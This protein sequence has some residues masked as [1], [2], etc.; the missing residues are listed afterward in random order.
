MKPVAPTSA[1]VNGRLVV[2]VAPNTY[3]EQG[4]SADPPSM[5][6]APASARL[7]FGDVEPPTIRRVDEL[8][9]YEVTVPASP[10]SAVVVLSGNQSLIADVIDRASTQA[11]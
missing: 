11:E 7:Y 4:S 9:R 1:S 3:R 6:Y 10:R 8:D 5:R 2:R